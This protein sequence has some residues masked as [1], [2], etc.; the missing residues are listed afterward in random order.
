VAA[1]DDEVELAVFRFTLGI[2]GFDDALVPRVAGILGI[3]LILL[4]HVLSPVP[5][6]G[7]QS[8]VELLGVFLGVVGVAAPG[9][10][11]RLEELKPGKGRQAPA[12]QVEGG[13]NIFALDDS[14]RDAARKDVAWA[15]YAVLKNTNTCGMFVVNKGKVVACRGNLGSAIANSTTSDTLHAASEEWRRVAMSMSSSSSFSYLEDQRQ[16]DRQGLRDC[17]IIP[18][19][20]GSVLVFPLIPL[21]SKRD[22]VSSSLDTVLVLVSERERAMSN[23][24]VAWAE[25][26]A[27][28]L[29]CLASADDS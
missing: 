14:L 16:A 17:R 21:E 22:G 2:P 20:A 27:G 12:V 4:N 15:S 7:A 10:Q 18:S 1:G 9:L 8:R 11:K 13:T 24:E 19:G 6:A 25:G 26:I 3:F 28:R 23:K 5:T 29:S